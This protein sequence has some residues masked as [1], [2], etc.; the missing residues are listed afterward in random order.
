M[1]SNFAS[2]I[3]GIEITKRTKRFSSALKKKM[4]N[5]PMIKIISPPASSHLKVIKTAINKN[6]QGM[7]LGKLLTIPFIP[8][9]KDSAPDKRRK[10]KAGQQEPIKQFWQHLVLLLQFYELLPFPFYSP[11]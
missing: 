2:T 1:I 7:V 9:P 4:V 11:L 3:N 6:I 5:M 10:Q 8:P